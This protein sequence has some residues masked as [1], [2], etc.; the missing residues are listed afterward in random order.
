MVEGDL[1]SVIFHLG[2]ARHF[3]YIWKSMDV[4]LICVIIQSSL[5]SF[6]LASPLHPLTFLPSPLLTLLF[7]LPLPQPH[8]SLGL[9]F[10][11]LILTYS[12]FYL[13]EPTS[14]NIPIIM[15]ILLLIKTVQPDQWVKS[16]IVCIKE[17]VFSKHSL[18]KPISFSN[19]LVRS[20]FS[21]PVPTSGN[22]PLLLSA[23]LQ[24]VHRFDSQVP[25][26]IL[27]VKKRNWELKVPALPFRWL[28]LCVAQMT[29]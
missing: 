6:T 15:R 14:Q 20:W 19:W 8:V 13:S 18:K 4:W 2:I 5:P 12:A 1:N 10:F 16:W 3:P 21:H 28:D 25:W 27:R 11:V 17:T 7:C 29:K 9:I 24:E 26:P 23:L 22:R